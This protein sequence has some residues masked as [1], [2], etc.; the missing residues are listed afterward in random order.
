MIDTRDLKVSL[1][2]QRQ[3]R[4]CG[5]RGDVS[6][7]VMG[8]VRHSVPSVHETANR[9][10]G[11]FTML[12][13]GNEVLAFGIIGSRIVDERSVTE[14]AI[15]RGIMALPIMAEL[16]GKTETVSRPCPRAFDP[17]QPLCDTKLRKKP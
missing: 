9:A 6:A 10:Y 15:C 12:V 7:R 2:A 8:L 14:C 13:R 17:N 1:N 4:Q 11:P 5:L 3:A 16:N